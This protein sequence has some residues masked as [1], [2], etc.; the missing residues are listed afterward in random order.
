MVLA[1]C[2]SY[3]CALHLNEVSRKYLKRFLRY[4]ADTSVWAII[5]KVC[6]PE[7]WFLCSAHRIIVLYICMKFHKNIS[8]DSYDKSGHNPLYILMVENKTRVTVRVF[9]TSSHGV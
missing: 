5:N 1:F 2:L 4:R 3:Y 8:N 9:C 7:L 6:K